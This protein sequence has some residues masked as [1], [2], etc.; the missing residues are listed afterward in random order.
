VRA[1]STC[2]DAGGF[3]LAGGP[4]EQNTPKGRRC[5]HHG[6]PE[7]ALAHQRR[8]SLVRATREL[9]AL[10]P[11]TPEPVFE[12]RESIVMWCQTM[13]KLVLVG[14]VEP[15]LADSARGFS[16]LALSAHELAALDRL[17]KLER[18]IV[19]GQRLA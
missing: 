15:R 7:K 17:E 2:G 11:D 13:A 5:V 16:L 8:S 14:K 6:D 9:K 4:C 3:N 19:K 10:G 18:V 12:S 1:V